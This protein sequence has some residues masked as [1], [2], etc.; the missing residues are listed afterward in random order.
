M[1][2]ALVTGSAGFIGAEATRFFAAK[3]LQ[4]VGIDNDM[5]KAF[6]GEEASTQWSRQELETAFPDWRS[7][8]GSSFSR[9]FM[10]KRFGRENYRVR[11]G[12]RSY[13]ISPESWAS[14]QERPPGPEEAGRG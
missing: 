6:F 8:Y 14:I 7:Q 4:V 2:V 3:G 12:G 1:G 10:E 9:D 11:K 5:R 13:R